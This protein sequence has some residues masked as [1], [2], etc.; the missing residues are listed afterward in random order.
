MKAYWIESTLEKDS[1]L[2]IR[3]HSINNSDLFKQHRRCPLKMFCIQRAKRMKLKSFIATA[4]GTYTQIRMHRIEATDCEWEPTITKT[5]A[6]THRHSL[7]FSGN[8][9]IIL[10]LINDLNGIIIC[11]FWFICAFV[12]VPQQYCAVLCFA[13]L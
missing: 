10:I 11:M 8:H 3:L 7:A 1:I 6:R 2:A 4:T 13:V 12:F 9:K 5:Y